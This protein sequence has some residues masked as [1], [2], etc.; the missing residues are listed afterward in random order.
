MHFDAGWSFHKIE[1]ATGEPYA[2]VNRICSQHK[3]QKQKK[4]I[5]KKKIAKT[6][7]KSKEKPG[8]EPKL[9]QKGPIICHV[10]CG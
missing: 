6:T 8:P 4:T 5:V 3:K 10:T 9:S 7:Q 2:T 1:E